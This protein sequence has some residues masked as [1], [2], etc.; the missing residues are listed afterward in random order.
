MR[1]LRLSGCS[2]LYWLHGRGPALPG[3]VGGDDYEG[4]LREYRWGLR[5][6]AGDFVGMRFDPFD[7]EIRGVLRGIDGTLQGC[8][9]F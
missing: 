2:A 1:V 5:S 4:A 7:N 6:R 9:Y 3:I 8:A